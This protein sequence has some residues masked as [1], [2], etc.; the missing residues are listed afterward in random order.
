MGIDPISQIALIAMAAASAAGTGY[1]IAAGEAGKKAQRRAM[2]QQEQAQARQT[3]IARREQRS[4]EMRM[5]EANRQ[6]PDISSIM[7]AAQEAGG[8]SGTMLT[9][10]QGINPQDLNLGRSSLLGG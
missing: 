10:P 4:S 5:R 2:Q 9:G 7:T 6:Q 8:P 1:S 3:A